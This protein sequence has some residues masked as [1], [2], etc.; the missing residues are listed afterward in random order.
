MIGASLIYQGSS[1]NVFLS[2]RQEGEAFFEFTDRYS[3]FDWGE[4]PDALEHKGAS[5]AS[6]GDS[7]FGH[8]GR[9]G[10]AHHGQGLV[11][12]AGQTVM[13]APTRFMRVKSVRVER[14]RWDG[15]RW[16]YAFYQ[17]RPENCLVPLEVIFRWGAPAGSSLLTRHP[18][19][20][21]GTRF[22]RPLVE[23]TT[24]L[25]TGDRH[26]S[27]EEAR[28]IAGLTSTEMN[29]LVELTVKAAT[30]L[31]ELVELLHGELWDGKLEWAFAPGSERVRDFVLVDAVGLDELRVD[32]QGRTLS[33]EFLR[34]HYRSSDW[35]QALKLAKAKA[36]MGGDFCGICLKELHQAPLPLPREVKLAAETMYQCFANDLHKVLTGRPL[37][38]DGMNLA[39]W[40]KEFT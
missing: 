18:E 5:L 19:M 33:K 20:Q 16:D 24:K 38:A 4:M 36:G 14:P 22:V 8:L 28:R 11:D 35:Y 30:G 10:I 29:R 26:V 12:V 2:E 25:E 3:I 6:M 17:S 39:H 9:L 7:F 21:A 32:Y 13:D 15:T 23:F 34:Q 27:A 37:F 31:R 1:K 40:A